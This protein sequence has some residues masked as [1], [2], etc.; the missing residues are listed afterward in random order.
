MSIQTLRNR[1]RNVVGFTALTGAAAYYVLAAREVKVLGDMHKAAAASDSSRSPSPRVCWGT[2]IYKQILVPVLF[3]LTASDPEVAHGIAVASGAVFGRIVFFVNRWWHCF[4]VY[5]ERMIERLGT[6]LLDG[7]TRKPAIAEAP[8]GSDSTDPLR[9]C[10]FGVEFPR[11]VGI[12]AGFDKNGDL[13]HLFSSDFLGNGFAEIG[14]VSKEPWPGNPRP[15]LFRLTRDQ[16]I[17]NR[18][19]LNNK[20]AAAMGEKLGKFNRLVNGGGT[21]IGVNITKTP[22]PN[23]EN[24]AAVAD[25]VATFDEVSPYAAYINV[26]ISCPNTA[27]GKTFEDLQA[28]EALLKALI[29]RRRDDCPDKAILVKLSPPPADADDKYYKGVSA[30][31]KKALELGVDGFVMTN[32]V[33]DRGDDLG[34]DKSIGDSMHHQKGGISGRPIRKRAISLV[35]HVYKETEGKVPIIGCGGVFTADDAYKLIRSGASLVQIYTGMIYEGPW[36]FRDIHNGL[37]ELLRRDG[38]SSI[39]EAIGVDAKKN[40]AAAA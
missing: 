7:D 37:I 1:I 22:S 16:G 12:A 21:P 24:E 19:G 13:L 4:N 35:R 29:A 34:L 20:G 38:Y 26:N 36:I 27:E 40:D 33:P 30:L 8:V 11:P 14:S 9:Q 5:R 18:M 39:T 28:L 6:L 10:L 2:R 31:V 25:M 17:I 15:R 3:P 32:T 23:I